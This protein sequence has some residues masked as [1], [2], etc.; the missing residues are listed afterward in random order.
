[1]NT[2]VQIPNNDSACTND[3]EPYEN[4]LLVPDPSSNGPSNEDRKNMAV[5]MI[6][7]VKVDHIP[8]PLNFG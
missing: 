6:G 1:M 4:E 7:K 2:N 5:V 3:K 8:F